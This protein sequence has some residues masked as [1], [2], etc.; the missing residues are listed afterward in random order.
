MHLR[1]WYRDA[2]LLRSLV[3][4]SITLGAGAGCRD[5]SVSPTAPDTAPALV[6]AAAA[7]PAFIQVS[8]GGSHQCG[9]ATDGRA[10]CWGRNSYGELGIGS[11][12]G[13]ESCTEWGDP[14]STRPVAVTGGLTFVHV[15]AGSWHSCGL[16][17]DNRIFC[18]GEGINGELGNGVRGAQSAPVAVAGTRHYRQV[19]TG[20]S[21]TCAIDTDRAAYCWGSNSEGQ[22]GNPNNPGI[23]LKPLLVRGKHE[24][25]QLS[26][27]SAHTCGVTT[28]DRA[29]CWGSNT[30]GQ[31]GDGTRTSRPTPVAVAGG[32]RFEQIEAGLSHTCGVTTAGKAYCWGRNASGE[33]GDGTTTRRLAPTAVAGSRLFA[34]VSAA[35]GAATC[36]VTRS[37][38]GFCWGAGANGTLGNGTLQWHDRPTALAGDL[39]FKAISAGS[40]GVATGSQAYCWGGNSEGQVGDGTTTDRLVPVPV[41][42]PM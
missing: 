3:L 27:G 37:G 20:G 39:L 35:P 42:A 22:L 11:A 6:A 8:Y 21:H 10:Y 1:N 36:G 26:G 30:E 2:R 12:R 7:A 16:T 15:N 14:C 18:W 19:R 25:R 24:W 40:C 17:T 32:L 41:A 4:A 38:K 5:D 13:P 28:D 9:T 29:F 33:L 31:L 34:N 23:Q